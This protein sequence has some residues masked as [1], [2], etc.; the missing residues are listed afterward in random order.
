MTKLKRSMPEFSIRRCKRDWGPGTKVIPALIDEKDNDVCIIYVDDD[1]VYHSNMIETLIAYSNI[2]P[3]HA[4][5]NAGAHLSK[6]IG[7]YHFFSHSPYDKAHVD[8]LEGFSGVFVQPKFFD[9]HKLIDT[10]KYPPEMFYQDDVYLSGILCENGKPRISTCLQRSI[11]HFKEFITGYIARNNSVSLSSTVNKD[12]H[13][14]NTS[15]ACFK[16]KKA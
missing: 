6:K 2:Y 16:W 8:I 1:M 7:N 10:S 15:I 5:C 3:Q 12:K 14:F 13:N 4:I 11:P 9:F